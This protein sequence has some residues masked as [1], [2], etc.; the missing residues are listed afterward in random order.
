[1]FVDEWEEPEKAE[2]IDVRNN[3]ANGL[4]K[5]AYQAEGFVSWRVM[6]FSPSAF[7]LT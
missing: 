5:Y 6:M 2:H 3:R 1:M 7:Y 4:Q